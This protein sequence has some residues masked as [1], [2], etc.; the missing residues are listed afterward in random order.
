MDEAREQ[1]LCQCCI[2]PMLLIK[3]LWGCPPSK[4]DLLMQQVLIAIA[5]Q[6]AAGVITAFLCNLLGL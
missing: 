3:M 6:V 1:M 5:A 4:E 2:L